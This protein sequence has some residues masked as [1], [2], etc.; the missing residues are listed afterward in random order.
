M[1]QQPQ[2]PFPSPTDTI[3][4][5]DGI[6]YTQNYREYISKID[7][8]PDYIR[9]FLIPMS[10]M[11]N[12][13]DFQYQDCNNVRAY[14]GMSV[15]GD[16]TSLKLVIVPVDANGQDVLK[17]TPPGD[18]AAEQSAIYDFTSPCPSV[19]DVDSPLFG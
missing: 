2:N 16:I 3:S 18:G 7:P 12:L 15:P 4:E 10:D 19:C 8:S 17:I 9:A 14:L 13:S 5:A 11:I 1:S 6:T